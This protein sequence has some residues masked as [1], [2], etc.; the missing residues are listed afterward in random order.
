MRA[1]LLSGRS[2]VHPRPHH[3]ELGKKVLVVLMSIFLSLGDRFL[4]G[5]VKLLASLFFPYIFTFTYNY[6]KKSCWKKSKKPLSHDCK[7]VCDFS[8]DLQFLHWYRK[9]W[10]AGHEVHG[11]DCRGRFTYV[12]AHYVR[13]L[14]FFEI[15]VYKLQGLY[16]L[17]AGQ[18]ISF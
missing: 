5:D 15:A 1:R 17:Q 2:W 4:S 12:P 3:Q 9:C 11:V 13:V 16:Q 7:V 8:N 14:T 10:A 6:F 18:S